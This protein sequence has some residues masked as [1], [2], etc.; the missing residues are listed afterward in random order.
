MSSVGVLATSLMAAAFLAGC[1][2]ESDDPR[3]ATESDDSSSTS[4]VMTS[5]SSE[6]IPPVLTMDDGEVISGQSQKGDDVVI[7]AGCSIVEWCQAPGSRGSVCRQQGCSIQNAFEECVN[8]TRAACGTP[9]C[10][11]IFIASDGSVGRIT[12]CP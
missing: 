6:N 12:P 9:R 2:A 8:E 3:T 10:P 7:Q 11:W 4:E 1:T 5:W